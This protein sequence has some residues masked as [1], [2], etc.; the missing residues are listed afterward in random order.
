MIPEGPLPPDVIAPENP[1]RGRILVID[2]EPD[3]RESLEA[4]L[5]SENYRVELAFNATEGLKKLET[6]TYDLVLVDL[7]MPDKSGM[8]V[9]EEIRLRDRETPLF[10]ITAYGSIEVAV[11]ALKRGAN[12]YFAKPW[13]NE[14]LLIEIERMISKHRLERENTEL[15]RALK[16]R[17]SFPNIVGKSERMMKI[18]DL[19]AQVA[20]SRATILIT[21]ETGTG[22]ELIANAIHAYSARSEHPFVPVHS[23]S[24]P[25]DLLESA[26]FGHVKGAF[27]G[28]V[29]SRK[30]YFEIANR[31][32]IFFDEIGTISL[33]TQTKLLRVIQ[34]R[35][36]MPLGSTETI[37]VDVRIVAATNAELKKA[38][39]EG[40]FREDLYYRLNVINLALPPLR[41]RKEDIPALVDHFFGK[42]CK[43]NEK[44]LDAGGRSVLRFEPEAMQILMDHAWP[45]NVR[46]LENVVERAVVL[47]SQTLVPVDVL[48]EHLLEAKGLRIRRDESG[49]LA[50]D[51]SLFEIVADF[52]RRKIIEQ[53]ETSDWSQTAAAEALHV[54]LSTLNQKIKR[55]NI[56]IRKRGA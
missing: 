4:L 1:S 35:E 3:I 22:K 15:K 51:A 20:A 36:F 17:Y 5:S 18:L 8:E 19:V 29:A 54:P 47:A 50:A 26:L 40:K 24:V 53:L 16:Q 10:M 11:E 21:G 33:E 7:M 52:E 14:K 25:P 45:G 38:V 31:G 43:E 44:Y 34:E 28:A 6:S 9:L 49:R 42:Y 13:D 32:T 39:E 46:E 30:G 41:D 12:D 27:T 48:P 56:E 23:G 55:L 2:D 37:R